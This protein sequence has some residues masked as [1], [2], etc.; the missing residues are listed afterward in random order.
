[1]N[2]N[3]PIYYAFHDIN[4]NPGLCGAISF[5]GS[6]R[7]LYVVFQRIGPFYYVARLSTTELG[8]LDIN[9]HPAFLTQNLVLHIATDVEVNHPIAYQIFRVQRNGITIPPLQW[10]SPS[11]RLPFENQRYSFRIN[12]INWEEF[13]PQIQMYRRPLNNNQNHNVEIQGV[14]NAWSEFIQSS[15]FKI[16]S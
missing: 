11:Y 2:A 9:F 12:G 5:A 6:G 15:I 4:P 16:T 10:N 13:S 8:F 7:V 1:M 14:D 3:H